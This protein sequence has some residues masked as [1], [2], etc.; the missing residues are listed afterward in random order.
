MSFQVH[1]SRTLFGCVLF[2]RTRRRRRICFP[3]H[4]CRSFVFAGLVWFGFS[5]CVLGSRARASAPPHTRIFV[6]YPPPPPPSCGG[7]VFGF[8]AHA[9]PAIVCVLRNQMHNINTDGATCVCNYSHTLSQVSQ[10]G[11]VFFCACVRCVLICLSLCSTCAA[12]ES[13]AT[14]DR[15]PHHYAVERLR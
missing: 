11:G 13:C 10:G 8:G 4:C 14:C 6:A 2:L 5:V 9:L 3:R 7:N 15:R 1:K 12:R